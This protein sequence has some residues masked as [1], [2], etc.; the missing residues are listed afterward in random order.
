MTEALNVRGHA[1][2]VVRFKC[3][4]AKAKLATRHDLAR[5]FSGTEE[6]PFSDLDLSPRT[7]QRFPAILSHL[8]GQKNLDRAS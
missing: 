5:E 2:L 4:R 3:H 6:N 7:H 1:L 8:P